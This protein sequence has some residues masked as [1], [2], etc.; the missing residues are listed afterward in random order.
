MLAASKLS[1]AARPTQST[2]T[3]GKKA[4]FCTP[5]ILLGPFRLTGEPRSMHAGDELGQASGP[6]R[7][8]STHP[9]LDEVEMRETVLSPRKTTPTFCVA[10]FR[11]PAG[12]VNRPTAPLASQSPPLVGPQVREDRT[13]GTG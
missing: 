13:R 2:L 1:S 9:T 4:G 6:H 3:W 5:K 12:L 10:A 8:Y 11:L 7:F